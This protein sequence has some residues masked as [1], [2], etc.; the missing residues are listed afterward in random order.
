MTLII[1]T[2]KAD[3]HAQTP[4]LKQLR[5]WSEFA[6]KQQKIRRAELCIRIVDEKESA[7]LNKK[8]R[9][10]SGPTNILSFPAN[11]PADLAIPLLGDLV[12]CAAVVNREATEQGKARAAHWAHMVIHGS[13]HLLGFDH[14]KNKEATKME[15][16]EVNIL[17]KLGFNNPYSLS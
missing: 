17:R 11:L 1:T 2:Q 10:K 8:Y 12:I 3:R 13:L 5:E 7:R 14:I 9:L 4:S 6:L 15:A 16:Q